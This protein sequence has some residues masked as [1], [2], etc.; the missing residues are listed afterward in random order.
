M[1]TKTITILVSAWC[2]ASGTQVTLYL[3]PDDES[4]YDYAP[5]GRGEPVAAWNR[6]HLSILCPHVDT[7]PELMVAWLEQPAQQETLRRLADLYEGVHWDGYNYVG[8]WGATMELE[9]ELEQA[10]EDEEIPRYW[11]AVD[12]LGGSDSGDLIRMVLERGIEGAA[13]DLR[14]EGE[15]DG[16]HVRQE[17][18]EAALQASIEERIYDLE[19]DEDSDPAEL[20]SLRAVVGAA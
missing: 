13:R 3:D 18:I 19:H 10:F 20:A 9:D 8:R 12:W 6:L 15:V 16:Q 4:V 1:I 14:I 2:T 11:D 5:V 7:V 17:D